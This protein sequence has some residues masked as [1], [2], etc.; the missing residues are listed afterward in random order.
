VLWLFC[1]VCQAEQDL[2]YMNKQRQEA[3]NDLRDHNQFLTEEIASHEDKIAGCKSR[4]DMFSQERQ[5]HLHQLR[6]MKE[7]TEIDR[8][9]VAAFEAESERVRRLLR[10]GLQ[11]VQVSLC[12]YLWVRWCTSNLN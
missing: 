10:S 8:K 11:N 4:V 2:E 9:L 12:S 1:V 5:K 6:R 3:L 7:K